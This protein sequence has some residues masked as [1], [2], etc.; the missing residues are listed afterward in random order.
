MLGAF[1]ILVGKVYPD[2]I[3]KT[4]HILKAFYDEDIIDEDVIIEWNDKVNRVT[5]W[6]SCVCVSASVSFCIFC[7]SVATDHWILYDEII[8]FVYAIVGFQ[9]ACRKREGQGNQGEGKAN[10]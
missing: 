1:E 3:T 2:L 6:Y 9:K 8:Y 4:P 7:P 5:N 10:H